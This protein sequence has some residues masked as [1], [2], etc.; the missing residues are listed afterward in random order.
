KLLA[1]IAEPASIP[2]LR[3]LVSNTTEEQ[4]IRISALQALARLQAGVPLLELRRWLDDRSFWQEH[5]DY[6]YLTDLISL[7]RSDEA[8][9]TVISFLADW[10]P[11]ERAR[12]LL[13]C[14]KAR[15][16]A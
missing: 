15:R 16:S 6:C 9:R 4:S 5:I 10:S 14:L 2:C 11:K 13:D 3:R 12:L 1:L 8:R 7:F